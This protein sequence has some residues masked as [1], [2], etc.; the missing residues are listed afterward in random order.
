MW[1]LGDG[2]MNQSPTKFIF[3][4]GKGEGLYSDDV[5]AEL[6]MSEF[7]QPANVG[8]LEAR[9]ACLAKL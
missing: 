4:D 5:L 3:I 1:L 7:G 9:Q 2:L 6:T 8:I